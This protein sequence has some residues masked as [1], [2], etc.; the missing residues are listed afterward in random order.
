MAKYQIYNGTSWVD[1]CDCTTKILDSNLVW[2]ELNPRDCPVRYWD[3]ANWCLVECCTCPESF[4]LNIDGTRCVRIDTV[5]AT[6]LGAGDVI[7]KG[8]INESQFGQFGAHFWTLVDVQSASLPFNRPVPPTPALQALTDQL[9]NVYPSSVTSGTGFWTTGFN[10]RLNISGIF[11]PANEWAGFS[12]CIKAPTTGTYY[13]GIAADN[14]CRFR[15][16]GLPILE[17]LDSTDKNHKTWHVIPY[18]LTAGTHIIEMEGQDLGVDSA[19]GV[20]IYN[21]LDFNTLLNATT[22]AEVNIIFSSLDR[23]GTNFDIG[24]TVGYE[25][26]PGYSLNLCNGIPSCSRIQ[27]IDCNQEPFV[28]LCS[29]FVLTPTPISTTEIEYQINVVNPISTPQNV[30][31]ILY[32]ETGMDI[33]GSTTSVIAAPGL[34]PVASFTGLT[35][36]TNYL[37]QL[38]F[39]FQTV[40]ITCNSIP[41]NTL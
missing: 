10:S 24:D 14:L 37:I 2:K 40:F 13:V 7:V 34:Q 16:D 5:N 6:F 17:L 21:P 15:I 25:C 19:F 1:I 8:D 32:D 39:E 11:A 23:I 38:Q 26:P 27:N 4:E 18:T 36:G 31:V 41:T 20:E 22:A 35:T 9:G 3:G 12:Q 33:I 30:L 29:D 28:P